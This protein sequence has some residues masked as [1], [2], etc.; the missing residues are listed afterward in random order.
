MNTVV[1]PLL[2]HGVLVFIDEILVHSSTLER[3]VGL[4]RRVLQLLTEHGLKVKLSK[5]SFAVA[6][7]LSSPSD[8]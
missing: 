5:C 2:R 7:R 8:R 3:H 4:L 6:D 1:E